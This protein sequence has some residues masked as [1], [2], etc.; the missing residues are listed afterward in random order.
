[1]VGFLASP[2]LVSE[3]KM[4]FSAILHEN[5]TISKNTLSAESSKKVDLKINSFMINKGG[6]SI[7][8]ELMEYGNFDITSKIIVDKLED[9]ATTLLGFDVLSIEK[10]DDTIRFILINEVDKDMI[11][12][13]AIG[14]ASDDLLYEYNKLWFKSVLKPE[15][16]NKES[17]STKNYNTSHD[18]DT[19]HSYNI[20]GDIFTETITIG[21]YYN[22]PSTTNGNAE[23]F[24]V[25]MDIKDKKTKR[26]FLN[27]E[28][29]TYSGNSLYVV[30]A[31]LHTGC[32]EGEYVESV[33]LWHVGTRVG[34][35]LEVSLQFWLGIPNVPFG[36]STSY[37]G[38]EII[39]QSSNMYYS[40]HQENSGSEKATIVNLNWNAYK[41]H[42]VDEND[43][44]KAVFAVTTDSP[45]KVP[46]SKRFKTKWSY[47]VVSSGSNGG[48][49]VPSFSDSESFTNSLYYTL[50]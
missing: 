29:T 46:G 34:S 36:I 39:S 17:V 23:D 50:N 32:D 12:I 19:I 35:G 38:S 3:N 11:Y 20:Y 30:G 45:Y 43:Y 7:S 21:Y 25:T 2:V 22:W 44:F 40:F 8:G 31:S 13:D 33:K 42:L 9:P 1:M 5:Y 4:K 14:L 48:I 37:N 49:G 15:V 26:E 27:G 28:S 6:L 18:E 41:Y 16:E 24:S 47:H 10:F